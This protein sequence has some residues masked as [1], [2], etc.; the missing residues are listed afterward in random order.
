LTFIAENARKLEGMYIVVKNDLSRSA[1]EATAAK[2]TDLRCANWASRDYKLLYRTSTFAGGG[3]LWSLEL[4]TC[5]SFD[6][7]FYCHLGSFRL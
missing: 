6:D 4:G 2:L 5:L 7:P 1:R 3:T